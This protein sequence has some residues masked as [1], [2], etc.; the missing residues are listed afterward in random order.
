MGAVRDGGFHRA[1]SDAR[2]EVV[3]RET[4]GPGHRRPPDLVAGR[5]HGPVGS[6][7][8]A[9]GRQV[10]HGSMGLERTGVEP[11]DPYM[12]LRRIRRLDLGAD[13]RFVV[14]VPAGLAQQIVDHDPRVR[15]G[16][17]GG[18]RRFLGRDCIARSRRGVITPS[19]RDDSSIIAPVQENGPCPP[20]RSGSKV[21]PSRP[22]T[23]PGRTCSKGRPHGAERSPPRFTC[24]AD[25]A[26]RPRTGRS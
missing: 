3:A 22:R 2:D 18:H 1:A 15:F 11:I 20:V 7:G 12:G 24:S 13:H 25:I 19:L 9:G 23:E 10:V 6:E 21:V 26:P 17:A 14:Q 4:N 8:A 5:P 16:I